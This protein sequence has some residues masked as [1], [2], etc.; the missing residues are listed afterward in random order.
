MG[1][2]SLSKDKPVKTS[3]FREAD[4]DFAGKLSYA[5]WQFVFVPVAVP[6]PVSSR[7]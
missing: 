2:H 5:D 7:K 3:N 6:A 4:K 1:V